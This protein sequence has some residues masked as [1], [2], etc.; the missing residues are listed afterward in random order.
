MMLFQSICD[1][2]STLNP[3]EMTAQSWELQFM[4]DVSGNREKAVVTII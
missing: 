3:P 4:L 2:V 1:L